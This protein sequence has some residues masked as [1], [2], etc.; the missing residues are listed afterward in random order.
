M[1]RIDLNLHHIQCYKHRIGFHKSWKCQQK[2]LQIKCAFKSNSRSLTIHHAMDFKHSSFAWILIHPFEN[3]ELKTI[4]ETGIATSLAIIIKRMMN[5]YICNDSIGGEL[6]GALFA[7]RGATN[8]YKNIFKI[9]TKISTICI[10][11]DSIGGKLKG[12]L[13][14][15]WRQRDLLRT[16]TDAATFA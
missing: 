7:N 1:M 2:S 3:H 4:F 13:F 10:C 12:A 14:S 6:K 15:I 16:F 5:L 8:G 11:N 9:C